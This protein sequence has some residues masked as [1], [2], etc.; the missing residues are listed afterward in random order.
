[1]RPS[2][3]IK[4]L[5]VVLLTVAAYLFIGLSGSPYGLYSLEYRDVPFTLEGKHT[6]DELA[7][8]TFRSPWD[9]LGIVVLEFDSVTIPSDD[10]VVL[11]LYRDGA[12]TPFH[13]HPYVIKNF[14]DLPKF[15][16]GLPL[17]KNSKGATYLMVLRYGDDRDSRQRL[18]LMPLRLHTVHFTTKS[19]LF[20]NKELL[21]HFMY[22]KTVTLV[23]PGLLPLFGFILLV[24][25]ISHKV[26]LYFLLKFGGGFNTILGHV[27]GGIG[28]TVRCPNTLQRISLGHVMRGAVV[29]VFAST[30]VFVL[31]SYPI[32]DRWYAIWVFLYIVCV[33]YLRLPSETHFALAL[34]GFVV[35]FALTLLGDTPRAEKAAVFVYFWMV[36]LVVSAARE[37]I[38]QNGNRIV[39]SQ[40]KYE[41]K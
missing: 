36:A 40:M 15:P 13:V 39:D 29:I 33:R 10:R 24:A 12:D 1:M 38:K 41:C 4:I 7:R 3:S 37:M 5:L 16:F 14:Y 19:E 26:L 32:R 31:S 9:V 25:G 2:K 22:N 11:E 30:M 18:K 35:F 28:I 17:Q 23:P 34:A 20:A 27:I 8:L 6:S 21:L